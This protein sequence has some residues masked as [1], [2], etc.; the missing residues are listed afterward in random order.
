[1]SEGDKKS[2]LPGASPAYNR[3]VDL[4]EAGN[5]YGVGTLLTVA[6]EGSVQGLTEEEMLDVERHMPQGGGAPQEGHYLTPGKKPYRAKITH[7]PKGD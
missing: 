4:I 2:R 3:V 5:F 7:A 1:M 6:S